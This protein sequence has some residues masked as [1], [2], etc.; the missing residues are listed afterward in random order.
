MYPITNAAKALFD[1]ES[2]QILRITGM[3]RNGNPIT[4]T[5]ANVMADGFRI[6]RY[7]CNTEKLEVGTAIAA[8]LSLTIDNRQGQ[9]N[10]VRFEGSELKVEI[11][12]ADWTQPNPE[13]LWIPCGYFTPD[14]QPRALS[15][16]TL[17]ALDR[18]MRFEAVLTPEPEAYHLSDESGNHIVDENGNSL[19][20]Y[21]PVSN[22]PCTVSDLVWQC[23]EV[24]GVELAASIAGLPNAGYPVAEIPEI[25]GD[26]TYRNLIQWAAGLMGTNAYVDWDGKLRFAWFDQS[27]DYETTT[28]NR[29]S[30]DM[31]ETDLTISGI[32][33][34]DVGGVQHI[35]G[36]P[37]YML[38]LTGNYLITADTAA[39][40]LNT[41][42][43]ARHAYAYRPCKAEVVGA[44]YLWP[45]D[46]IQFVD[47]HGTYHNAALTNVNFTVNGHT[48]IVSKGETDAVNHY[49]EPGVFTRRQTAAM[50]AT[51]A[52][53]N[54]LNEAVQSA[55]DFITGADGGNIRDIYVDGKRKEMVIMDTE[56]ITTA[57]K[58]W[59]WNFGGLGFSSNG[60]GGPYGLAITQD[61]SIVANYITTGTLDASLATIVNLDAGNIST[62]TLDA[63]RIAANTISISQ[64]TQAAQ[65][66]L[67]GNVTTKN[68]Y[69]KSTSSSSATGGSWQD[70][71]PTWEGGTYIWTRVAT[72]K[73]LA[74]GTTETTYSTEVY[75]ENLTHAMSGTEAVNVLPST[76]TRELVYGTTYTAAGITWTLNQDGSVTAKGTATGTSVYQFNG[77]TLTSDIPVLLLD[78]T[79]N[80]MLH[81]CPYG[82]STSTYRMSIRATANGTTPSSSSGT[83][84]HDVGSGV[85]VPVGRR[86]GYIYA[87]IYSGTN[88]GTDGLTFYPMLETGDTIHAYVSTHTGSGAVTNR[89]NDASAREQYIYKSAVSGTTTMSEMTTWV[90]STADSQDVW[91]SRR[92]TYNSQYPVLFI[93]LQSQTTIQ[94]AAG[95]TCSC[96]APVIDQTTTVI[97]GGHITTGTIDASVVNVIK[98]NA[99]NITSGSIDASTITV[100]NIDA[101]NISGGTID[102]DAVSAKKLTILDSN[103][104][105]VAS[106]DS[107]VRI[108]DATKGHSETDYNSFSLYDKGNTEYLHIGD[109]RD[110]TGQATL[111]ETFVA[112][113]IDD[114]FV[115]SLRAESITSVT[116]NSSV[117]AASEYYI[118]PTDEHWLVM[119][120]IPNYGDIVRVFYVTEDPTYF[121]DFGTRHNN[122]K[123]GLY[124]SIVGTDNI[125]SGYMS[126]AHGVGNTASGPMSRVEGYDST[127]DWEM[128]R[129]IGT[130]C[131]SNGKQSRADG[132]DCTAKGAFSRAVGK[133][134]T[135]NNNYSVADGLGLQTN[136]IGQH[137]WGQYNESPS[138]IPNETHYV[139][140]VGWGTESNPENIREMSAYGYMWIAGS[141]TQQSDERLKV[142]SGNVPD[143]SGI[144][145][146]RFK[147]NDKK[148][149]DKLEHIGYYAQDVEKVA[150]YLVGTSSNGYKSLD[151]IGF[152]CAKVESMERRIAELEHKLDALTSDGK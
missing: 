149:H 4:I 121:H 108:G 20:V 89:T 50:E 73:T 98:M 107:T 25:L 3:D 152:L 120:T 115:L 85:K 30:S 34:T 27:A 111:D 22:F 40:I 54:H 127:A 77:Q 125:A 100:T 90:T 55:T 119:R 112:N 109:N 64:M 29:Y 24:C 71:V 114:T 31:H 51:Y 10:G 60:Y 6:D 69:Y 8:E 28:A 132:E 49:A 133:N 82:G 48:S 9:F 106:F 86:Y 103:D 52:T 110:A 5:D 93:A 129:A 19:I 81:G 118:S 45:M 46:R 14:E 68:Q 141:L 59:R 124:S 131:N 53:N 80:Y 122:S 151:Y 145:A 79:R 66:A 72:T 135:A 62:G 67:V 113:G 2:R 47:Q 11:G 36:D 143:V 43:I 44:P 78:P 140:V 123:V 117:V 136:H 76:Y 105:E 84:Y 21:P 56:D 33:F 63:A 147:W 61:G 38:D 101:D 26:V 128:S 96:T 75:D 32:T 87:A 95:N 12:I 88:C 23:C 94:K 104:N 144:R 137:V 99:S 74:D 150:P 130:R 146:R 116:L 16:I 65:A 139:E 138:H 91:T 1:A 134:C 58:V 148:P 7:A 41:L 37:N 70:T 92:P 142:E 42:Y 57:Q 97:D 39:D 17:H 126:H 18:M 15:T 35:A 83:V 102:G 13:I